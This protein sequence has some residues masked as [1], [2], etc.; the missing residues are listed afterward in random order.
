M[1]YRCEKGYPIIMGQ[2]VKRPFGFCNRCGFRYPLTQLRH[3]F[4]DLKEVGFRYCPTCWDP[5]Q[6]QNQ[7]GRWPIQDNQ[8][9]KNARPDMSL[10]ESRFG[11]SIR[12]DFLESADYWIGEEFGT[13]SNP[14][15]TWKSSSE[16]ITFETNGTNPSLVRSISSEVVSVDTSVYKNIRSRMKMNTKPTP[17]ESLFVDMTLFWNRSTDIQGTFSTDRSLAVRPPHWLSM[18][19]E[20]HTVT[21][22]LRDH[23]EWS[24]I[25]SEMR[26]EFFN[27]SSFSEFTDAEIELDFIRA[28][29]F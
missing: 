4:V 19:A 18:G 2:P 25:V 21:W 27:F 8:S 9:L 28:E 3:S 22:A 11:D 16:T 5:D 6:P 26:F 10:E 17:S 14:V 13:G 23:V 15:V 24:G 7:L 1:E 20:W 29:S 12:W